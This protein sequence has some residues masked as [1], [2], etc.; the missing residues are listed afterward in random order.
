M[1]IGYCFYSS[2]EL[3]GAHHIREDTTPCRGRLTDFLL[4]E[5]TY[6]FANLYVYTIVNYLQKVAEHE[7]YVDHDVIYLHN[8]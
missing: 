2:Y 3:R 4:P 5:R 1:R 7:I 6:V 8:V